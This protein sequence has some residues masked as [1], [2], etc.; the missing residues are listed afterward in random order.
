MRPTGISKDL[1]LGANVCVNHAL[2][3]PVLNQFHRRYEVRV[4]ADEDRDIKQVVYRC[5]DQVR[6]ERGIYPLFYGALKGTTT[7][8][9]C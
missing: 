4:G 5:L 9:A 1:A 6:D 8:R 2:V 3:G 7:T